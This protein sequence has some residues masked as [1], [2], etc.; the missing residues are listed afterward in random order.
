M[1]TKYLVIILMICGLVAFG[2]FFTQGLD[3]DNSTEGSG[4]GSSPSDS[5]VVLSAESSEPDALASVSESFIENYP[6]GQPSITSERYDNHWKITAE[7]DNISVTYIVPKSVEGY[8]MEL[9][10]Y[11]K[12]GIYSQNYKLGYYKLTSKEKTEFKGSEVFR[13]DITAKL[14]EIDIEGYLLFDNRLRTRYSNVT[15]SYSGSTSISEDN[16]TGTVKVPTT[17]IEITSNFEENKVTRKETIGENENIR[18]F[19]MPQG[20]ILEGP[21]Y[22]EL[23]DENLE[24]NFSKEF[25]YIMNENPTTL[26]LSVTKQEKLS[27]QGGQYDCWVLSGF[28]SV[29]DNTQTE[30]KLWVSKNG[31]VVPKA[32]VTERVEGK[33]RSIFAW[34]LLESSGV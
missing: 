14:G 19:P 22:F 13:W 18:E 25:G 27:V 20:E 5:E 6:G 17:T 16:V 15:S 30:V 31:R 4:S 9:G 26:E 12:Y 11:L 2:A 28:T 7:R 1:K 8:E 32:K 34:E 3:S 23:L 24:E 33:V 10:Q 29:Q 21:A